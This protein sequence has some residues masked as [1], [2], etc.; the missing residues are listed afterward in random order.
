VFMAGGDGSQTANSQT[1]NSL[2]PITLPRGLANKSGKVTK[3]VVPGGSL[4]SKV[5]SKNFRT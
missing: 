4:W 5:C 2:G 1:S 3:N